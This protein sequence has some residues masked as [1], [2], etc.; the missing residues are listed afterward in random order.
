[1]QSHVRTAGRQFQRLADQPQRNLRLTAQFAA[2]DPRRHGRGQ[3]YGARLPMREPRLFGL[4]H[5][6]GGPLQR[7][8]GRGQLLGHHLVHCMNSRLCA[9]LG[10]LLTDCIG[11]PARFGDDFRR[12]G[13]GFGQT[14]FGLIRQIVEVQRR[15]IRAMRQ[16]G[17]S[18]DGCHVA[19]ARDEGLGP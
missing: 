9:L 10:R 7:R 5:V 15:D 1:M 19:G 11:L 17:G 4:L 6:V 16:I 12:F 13:P 14:A 18:N 8:D 3:P 2:N